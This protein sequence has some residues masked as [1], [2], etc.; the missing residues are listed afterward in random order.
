LEILTGLKLS[1]PFA[2]FLG[3]PTATGGTKRQLILPACNSN[4]QIEQRGSDLFACDLAV[5]N[6]YADSNFG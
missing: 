2:L 6:F 1:L 4:F 3:I 5:S